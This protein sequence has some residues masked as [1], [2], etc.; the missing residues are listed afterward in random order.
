MTSINWEIIVLIAAPL[1]S[2]LGSFVATWVHHRRNIMFKK[3]ELIASAYKVA[4]DRIEVLYRIKR[5]SSNEQY[6]EEESMKI[7]DIFH[8]IQADTDYYESMLFL[9]SPALGKAYKTLIDEIKAATAD[10][11]QQAWTNDG[12]VA[13]QHDRTLT[14][15]DKLHID[16]KRRQF[17]YIANKFINRKI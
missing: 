15:S 3:K 4:T 12:G 8:Q 11:I 14:K 10:K 16:E 2:F 13:E 7:R 9:E 17:L 1:F 6:R 5:R